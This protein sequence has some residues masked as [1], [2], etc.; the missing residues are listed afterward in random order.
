[1]NL[2]QFYEKLTEPDEAYVL[3]E[4]RE[5]ILSTIAHELWEYKKPRLATESVDHPEIQEIFD[6]IKRARRHE[7]GLYSYSIQ[8]RI[9][10][11][12]AKAQE[13]EEVVEIVNQAIGGVVEKG[14]NKKVIMSG[15]NDFI[16]EK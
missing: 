16:R 14:L 5:N 15:K 3:D 1:M 13:G 8:S 10:L 4:D 2:F 6:Y 11:Q 12:M 9:L 7:S